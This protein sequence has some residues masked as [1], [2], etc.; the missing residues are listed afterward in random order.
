MQGGL[1]MGLFSSAQSVGVLGRSSTVTA[2]VNAAGGVVGALSRRCWE[3]LRALCHG[4][5][6]STTTLDFDFDF[7]LAELAQSLATKVTKAT[8]CGVVPSRSNGKDL[9]DLEEVENWPRTRQS[10]GG[11]SV[12]PSYCTYAL[13]LE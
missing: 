7:D 12:V 4:T 11:P 13:D 8:N 3:S 2:T 9:E 10:N 5:N 1:K 6:P